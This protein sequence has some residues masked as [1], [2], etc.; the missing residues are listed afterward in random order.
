MGAMAEPLLERV[1]S[2][3]LPSMLWSSEDSLTQVT[4]ATAL[5]CPDSSMARVC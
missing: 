1:S 4:P 5:E 3:F 2:D